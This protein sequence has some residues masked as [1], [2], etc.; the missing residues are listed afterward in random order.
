MRRLAALPYRGPFG[1]VRP[2]A[3]R[4][5]PLPPAPMPGRLGT[6]PLK[7]WRYV[8]V[9]TPEFMLCLARVRIGPA[10]QCFWALWDRSLRRQH[11]GARGVTL[12][13]GTAHLDDAGVRVELALT[14][15]AGV[16][17]ICPTR[18]GYAWTH[19]QGGIA[20]RGTV[21]LDGSSQSLDGRAIIDDTAAYYDR[22][23][24]WRWCAGVGK[25]RDGRDVA[26]NLVQGVNDPPASSERTVWIDGEPS[27]APAV[28][29]AADLRSAGSLRFAA[30][31]TLARRQN[32]LL[33][34][35]RYRQPF[36]SFSGRLPGGVE[37]DEGWGVM[38]D[39][40]VWW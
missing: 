40:D 36:G 37:L 8:G 15:A 5:L 25:A 34:R 18:S 35:S 39:H 20:A 11:Q 24:H 6:R 7:A 21:W 10:R 22:H 1:S 29:I 30:E 26:W 9:F 31:A 27:E 38:E 33:V 17:T 13:P 23:T 2:A 14:E 3:L 12:G 4:G 32:L 19:K 16:E 28:T